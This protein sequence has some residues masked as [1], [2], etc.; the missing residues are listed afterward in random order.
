MSKIDEMDYT[1][2]SF[3]QEDGKKSYTEIAKELNVSEGTVRT[4]INRMLKDNVFEF[5]IHMNP[6]KIGLN[7]QVIIGISTKLGYQESIARELNRFS[8][9]R[10]V[11]AFSGQHDLIMQAYFKNNDDLVHFV[12]KELAKIEGI[13]SADVNIE[14]KQYKDSFSYITK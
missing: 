5:I 12:N 2:L 4:R 6:N 8:E 9:V 7:V 1:I 11:G 3:L 10:F 13:I 14:L